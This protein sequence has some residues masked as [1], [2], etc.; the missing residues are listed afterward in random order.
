MSENNISRSS[1]FRS[2]MKKAKEDEELRKLAEKAQIH[3]MMSTKY[4]AIERKKL[5]EFEQELLK[6]I[7]LDI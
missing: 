2:K 3:P 5:R 7:E 4:N 6:N 1:I